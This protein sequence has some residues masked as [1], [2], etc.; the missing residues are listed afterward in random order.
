MLLVPFALQAEAGLVQIVQTLR[1]AATKL[2]PVLVESLDHSTYFVVARLW[3][4]KDLDGKGMRA[5]VSK[6]SHYH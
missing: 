5:L 2:L 4:E 3:V 6:R 1:V